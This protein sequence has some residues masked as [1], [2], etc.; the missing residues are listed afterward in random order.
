M[1][2]ARALMRTRLMKSPCVA[3]TQEYTS[4]AVIR[5]VGDHCRPNKARGRHRHPLNGRAGQHDYEQHERYH[6]EKVSEL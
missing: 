1:Q 2:E 5:T 3:V 4:G 6:E